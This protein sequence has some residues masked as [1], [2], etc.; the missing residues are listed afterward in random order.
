MEKWLFIEK[1]LISLFN[2]EYWPYKVIY[3]PV[4]IYFTYLGLKAR[5]LSFFVATNPGIK[6][7]GLYG[8][9]KYATLQKIPSKFL[10]KSILVTNK[11]SNLSKIITSSGVQFPLIVKPDLGERGIDVEKIDHILELEEYQQSLGRDFIIQEFV[12]SPIELGVF[13]YRLPSQAVGKI[14]SIVKKDFL[15]VTGDGQSTIEALMMKNPRARFQIKRLKKEK[16]DLL[17]SI[18]AKGVEQLLEPIGNHNRGTVFLDAS[19]LINDKLN[20][21]FDKISKHIGGFY[22]GRFDIKC[23]GIEP[24]YEGKGIKI[25]ELNGAKAE[26]AHIYQPGFPLL[27]AYKVLFYHWNMVYQIARENMHLHNTKPSFKIAYQEYKK[28]L[29]LNRS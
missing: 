29:R 1:K 17:A 16:P 6:N 3:F 25:L 21:I 4:A 9:S 19:N 7:G 8:D 15:K 26:P 22:Y 27:K 24:L 14:S 12:D 20:N 13:Y 2:W 5:N 11:T 28:H 18:P 23:E 10:P